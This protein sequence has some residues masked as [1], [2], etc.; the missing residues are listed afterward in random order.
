MD[1]HSKKY[2]L[3]SKVWPRVLP[4]STVSDP[5]TG[6]STWKLTSPHGA[7]LLLLHSDRHV[8]ISVRGVSI[9]RPM[10]KDLTGLGLP[11]YSHSRDDVGMEDKVLHQWLD[12]LASLLAGSS[13]GAPRNQVCA[14]SLFRHPSS[15]IVTIAFN[16]PE[17]SGDASNL[18]HCIWNWMKDASV[19]PEED[20]EKIGE[21]SKTILKASLGKTRR[22]LKDR[23]NSWALSLPSTSQAE[24]AVLTKPQQTFITEAYFFA[25]R[26]NRSVRS[27]RQKT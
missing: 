17:R 18:V 8:V 12:S 1:A 7:H 9:L 20:P 4:A 6:S 22:R 25:P 19:L 26:R 24:E 13:P 2:D 11:T 27:R 3:A 10:D 16:D 21:L 14:V 5:D 23:V 15:Y